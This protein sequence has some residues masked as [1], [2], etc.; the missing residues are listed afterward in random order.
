MDRNILAQKTRAYVGAL[1]LLFAH[2][3]WGRNAA[4]L[5]TSV[6]IPGTLAQLGTMTPGVAANVTRLFVA[7]HSFDEF[8]TDKG[9]F[10]MR[11]TAH[12]IV[13]QEEVP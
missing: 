13:E 6:P 7:R 12:L 8:G 11:S 3:D 2:Y 9:E 4:D 5:A 10:V 1:T